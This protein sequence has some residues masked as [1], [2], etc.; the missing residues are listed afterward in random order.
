MR[1]FASVATGSIPGKHHVVV[2][3]T[4][5]IVP[6]YHVGSSTD[7]VSPLGPCADAMLA[8]ASAQGATLRVFGTRFLHAQLSGS[9]PRSRLADDPGI[10]SSMCPRDKLFHGRQTTVK[11]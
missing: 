4:S 1:L 6:K 10:R 2:S 3:I 7:L 9:V 11:P 8:T 5:A